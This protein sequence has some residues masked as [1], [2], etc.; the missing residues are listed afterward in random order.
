MVSIRKETPQNFNQ[1]GVELRIQDG[2]TPEV[3]TRLENQGSI[4]MATKSILAVSCGSKASW[5]NDL[6]V[7]N[8]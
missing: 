3:A 8:Q 6:I 1:S 2:D 5:D 7:G 4:S